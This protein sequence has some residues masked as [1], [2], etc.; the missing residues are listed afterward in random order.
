MLDWRKRLGQILGAGTAAVDP[1]TLV[2]DHLR[3]G[4]PLPE[5]DEI[6]LLAIGKAA[7]GMARGAVQA[8]GVP[9]RSVVVGPTE[10]DLSALD[11][12]VG[13]HPIPGRESFEAGRRLLEAA[14]A[15]EPKHLVLV[16]LSGGASAMAEVPA[17]GV[18]EHQIREVAASLFK[19]GRP[20]ADINQQRSAL[21]ALKR[22]G[23]TAAAR[24]ARVVTLAISD[25]F[26]AGPEV[27][28][29]GPSIGSDVFEVLAD[30]STAAR[31]VV[32]ACRK[33]DLDPEMSTRPI[34]GPASDAG[35]HLGRAALALTNRA[36]LVGF[37]ETT[38]RV[39]GTGRGGRNQEL[40][41]AAAIEIAGT[42]VLVGSIG[43][44]GIDGPTGNAGAVVDGTTAKRGADLG[45]DAAA[46]LTDH[47]SATFLEAVGDVIVTGPTGTN[48]GDLMVAMRP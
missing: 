38:V 37:G 32:Q 30:G 42:N 15:A 35:S 3:L 10:A 39:D 5:H 21:S 17:P 27:I 25:V 47:D 33:A 45:L 26:D 40:A 13:N 6:V 20:I 2:R 19:S 28:G 18:S 4:P 44:D 9:A 12:F 29:S 8:L 23:I 31:A 24:P 14:G 34:T 1:E 36:A 43:T 16:L 41:L 7:H 46:H 11:V 48:V 22:G